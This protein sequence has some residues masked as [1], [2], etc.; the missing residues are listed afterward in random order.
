M[1]TICQQKNRISSLAT[2]AQEWGQRHG[3]NGVTEAGDR[4][5]DALNNDHNGDTIAEILRM[6]DY[7][8]CLRV[9]HGR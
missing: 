4:I 7:A 1:M 5:H 8:V 9:W 2:W 6:H 3:N